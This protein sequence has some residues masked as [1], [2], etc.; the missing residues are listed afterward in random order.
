MST[1]LGGLITVINDVGGST[2]FG[3]TAHLM[4]RG[5]HYI[6]MILINTAKETQKDTENLTKQQSQ[7]NNRQNMTI[8][9]TIIR[10]QKLLSGSAKFEQS[11]PATITI[12][13][14]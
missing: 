9:A 7:H 11:Y 3:S 4:R 14:Y 13:S 5:C 8:K 12:L 2:V 10:R 1:Y 6:L